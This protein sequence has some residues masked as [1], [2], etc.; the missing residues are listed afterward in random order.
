MIFK[1]KKSNKIK[2]GCPQH[3]LKW[4]Q[5]FCRNDRGNRIS[6]IMKTI[7]EIKNKSESYDE[8]QVGGHS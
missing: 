7:D 3:R 1:N 5:H 8:N 6:R 4:C 2:N